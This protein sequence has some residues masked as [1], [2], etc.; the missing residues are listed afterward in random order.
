MGD[1]ENSIVD[2]ATR[3]DV[4]RMESGGAYGVT[5]QLGEAL[6]WRPAVAT[7]VV[8]SLNDSFGDVLSHFVSTWV[9]EMFVVDPET[10]AVLG[11]LSMKELLQFLF[12]TMRDSTAPSP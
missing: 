10:D 11:Q 9:K 4:L 7:P 8:C 2:V 5:Q 1:S 12:D 6:S 3:S